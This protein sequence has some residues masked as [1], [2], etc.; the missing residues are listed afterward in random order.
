MG[1]CAPCKPLLLQPLWL[2][3]LEH[4]MRTFIPTSDDELSDDYF[5]AWF[6]LWSLHADD[7]DPAD[8]FATF[9]SF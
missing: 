8:S 3:N 2:P 6:A 4:D 1:C 7:I 5:A 9:C